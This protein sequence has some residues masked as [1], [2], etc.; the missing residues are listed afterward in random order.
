MQTTDRTCQN[1]EVKMLCVEVF[2]LHSTEN[3]QLQGVLNLMVNMRGEEKQHSTAD[4]TDVHS[5][6]S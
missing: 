1:C 5:I 4:N 3:Y 6:R 2:N